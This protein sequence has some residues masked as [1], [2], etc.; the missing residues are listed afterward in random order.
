MRTNQPED[1]GTRIKALERR[2][3]DLER[4]RTLAGAVLSQGNLEVRDDNGTTILR[5]GRFDYGGQ[6]VYGMLLS[7]TDGSTQMWAWDAGG[8]G[9][10]FSL[11][12]EA[13]NIIVSNDTASGQGLATPYIPFRSLPWSEV[14][15]PPQSTTSGT[16]TPLHRIH[17]QKQHPVIRAHLITQADA[18][19]DG[20]AYLSVGG[21]PISSVITIPGGDNSYRTLD[22]DL[23][24]SH[25]SFVYVDVEVRRTA[26][27]GAIRVGVAFVEG[28]QS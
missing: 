4:G 3:A 12:D 18:S 24:G 14:L 8:G 13:G 1:L 22:A 11:W 6:T 17:G 9:G 23:A 21:V 27:A 7:R 25:L 28:K 15:T 2:I 19:T 10:Y 26:G 20:E 16:F 5:V